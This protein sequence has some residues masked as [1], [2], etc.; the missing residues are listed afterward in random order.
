MA[1][2]PTRVLIP[3]IALLQPSL[4]SR[5]YQL[6]SANIASPDIFKRADDA[7]TEPIMGAPADVETA[8]AVFAAAVTSDGTCGKA[9]GGTTCGNW[10]LGGCCS[11]YGFCGDT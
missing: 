7:T 3:I 2:L 9:H 11:L 8:P 1:R 4:T 10:P 6:R 5:L